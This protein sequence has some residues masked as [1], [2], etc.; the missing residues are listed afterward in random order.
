VK[1]FNTKIAELE[2]NFT[3]M[4]IYIIIIIRFQKNNRR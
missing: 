1:N 2:S 3:G 4:Y